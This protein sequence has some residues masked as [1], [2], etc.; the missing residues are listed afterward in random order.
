MFKE[1]F[2]NMLKMQKVML[3]KEITFSNGFLAGIYP[4]IKMATSTPVEAL[5]EE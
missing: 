2:E 4:T 5:R 1:V 3:R